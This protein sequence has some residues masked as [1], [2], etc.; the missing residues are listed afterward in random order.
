M[1]L[2]LVNPSDGY[3]VSGQSC[4]ATHISLSSK[5]HYVSGWLVEFPVD[6]SSHRTEHTEYYYVVVPH[7]GLL[8]TDDR[9]NESTVILPTY[10]VHLLQVIANN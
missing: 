10:S 8:L 1:F 9:T 3:Y 4:K 5:Q 6:I 2:H 7:T